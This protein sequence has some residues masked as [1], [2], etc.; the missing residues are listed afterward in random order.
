MTHKFSKVSVI[1]TVWGNSITSTDV[2]WLKWKSTSA[3]LDWKAPP[4]N[5][6]N[7]DKALRP[8][9]RLNIYLR[10]NNWGFFNEQ[11]CVG[12]AGLTLPKSVVNLSSLSKTF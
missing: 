1:V 10:I 6:T 2:R 7:F 11:L 5:K 9:E 8:R 4:P 12:E 3:V